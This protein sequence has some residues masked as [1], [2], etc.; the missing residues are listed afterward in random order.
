M[1]DN[2]LI[3]STSSWPF[4]EIRRLLKDRKELIKKKNKIVFQTGYGPSG[5]PHIGT[6]GEVARTT[7]MINALLHIKKID[8]DLI[9]FSDD[10]DGLRK[11]PE[12]IPDASVLEENIGKPL[13]SIP[14]PFKKYNSFGEHNNEMLK[15]FLNKFN[16]KFNFKSSSDNYKKGIFNNSLL[17]VAEKYEDIMNIILPTLREERKKTYSPFL[18][19]CPDT[20]K[21]LEIP[22]ID[23]NKKNGK[24]VFDNNGK[25]LETEITNG[26]CKLQWKVDWAMRWFT[27]DVDFEMYGKDLTESAILSNKVCKILGKQP[28]NGFAY[29]LFLDEKG[30]K[31]SKSKGNGISMDQWLRYASPESLSLYMY[32][33]PKRAKKLYSAV[34]PKT[35][36]E[37]LSLIEKYPTQEKKDQLLNP[38]WHIHNGAPPKEKIVMSYSM[39]L[40]IVGSSNAKSKDILWKFINK[41]H[42]DINSKNHPIL[43][44]LTEFAINYFKDK[45][46][47]NK[48]F[49][50]P[51]NEE[52]KALNNLVEKLSMVSQHT[53]PEDIQTIIYTIGKE[54][55]FEKN[56]REWFKLIY[57]VVFG[58]EDGPRMGFFVSFFGIKETINLMKSKIN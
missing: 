40:N 56:L 26:K 38:V 39:L 55:G 44:S 24:I 11:V 21:V 22:M 48:K 46:E 37:Y 47:P 49:K 13:T 2:D 45:V 14:D 10:M 4:V 28:P 5:L 27:F 8:F 19:I 20:G 51:N 17:R 53:K 25:N 52:K 43:D 1:L 36:D 30:E 23:L 34:V 42:K 57:Q 9:T 58:E 15:K 7:M 41:F 29:E 33:N 35:V 32:P 18:P 50:I 16:F 6:F 3:K 12:N 31:I 54:N